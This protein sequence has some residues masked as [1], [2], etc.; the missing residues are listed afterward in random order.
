MFALALVFLDAGCGL[1]FQETLAVLVHL[2]FDDQ[3]LGKQKINNL[4]MEAIT[5]QTE[6]KSFV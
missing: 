4:I 2:Q 1:A 5:K 6:M 3:D